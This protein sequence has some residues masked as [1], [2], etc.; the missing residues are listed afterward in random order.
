MKEFITINLGGYP[1]RISSYD[2]LLKYEQGI[3]GYEQL[4]DHAYN[5]M[6]FHNLGYDK[7]PTGLQWPEF[8]KPIEWIAK[9]S[10]NVLDIPMT[11]HDVIRSY[12]SIRLNAYSLYLGCWRSRNW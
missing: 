3:D 11:K 6:L 2:R 5:S 9:E 10:T 8:N 12:K 7:C 4:T 1:V